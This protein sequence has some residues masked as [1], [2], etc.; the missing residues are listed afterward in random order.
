MDDAIAIDDIMSKDMRSM[1]HK[2]DTKI[3]HLSAKN[4]RLEAENLKLQAENKKLQNNV[5]RLKRK[6]MS[7]NINTDVSDGCD[8]QAAYTSLHTHPRIE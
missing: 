4:K 5:K 6:S 3:V 7:Q 8:F 2:L 1:I